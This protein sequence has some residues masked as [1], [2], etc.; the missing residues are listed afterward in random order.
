MKNFIKTLTFCLFGITS[1]AQ[2]ATEFDS[3]SVKLPRYASEVAVTTAIP[4]PTQGMLIYRNDTKS[5]WYF[6][7]TDWKN[8]EISSVSIPTPL[9][10]VSNTNTFSSETQDGASS[11]IIGLNSSNGGGYGIYGQH[12]GNGW[13]GY[14]LGNNAISA[15]GKTYL[16]GNVEIS[17]SNWLEFGKGLTKQ[18][19][20][21]KIVYNAFGEANTL[22]IVGGGVAS[23]GSDRKIKMWANGG[24]EFTGSLIT[25]GEIKPNG[26]S[27]NVGQILRSNGNGTMSWGNSM[28]K[29]TY[30]EILA[31][32]PQ[33]GDMV[34]DLTF[35]IVRVYNGSEW[36]LI[37]ASSSQD[38]MMAISLKALNISD[39]KI[40][41][42]NNIYITG[43]CIGPV[44]FGGIGISP[45][46]GSSDAFIG[47]FNCNGDILWL[48]R[49]GGAADTGA[50]GSELGI[51]VLGN[52]IMVGYFS[53]T[54]NFN[55]PSSFSNNVITTAGGTDN[56]IA[57]YTSTGD[58][59]WIKRSGGIYS[60]QAYS[61]TSDLFGNL[62][63]TGYFTE[64]ANF[65]T[66]SSFGTNEIVSA[67][68]YDIF[69]AKYNQNGEIIF[70]KRAGGTG[71]DLGASIKVDPSGI[72]LCGSFNS[73]ANF[74]TPNS[75]GSFEVISA[76]NSDI[77]LAKFSLSGD[78]IWIKRA[79]GIGNDSGYKIA[80]S[81][82][83]NVF[84]T[85]SFTGTANFNNPSSF[86]SNELTCPNYNS[87][88]G[89]Y[90]STGN[91]VWISKIEGNNTSIISD[92][93]VKINSNGYYELFITGSYSGTITLD[94]KEI[95]SKGVDHDIFISAIVK[96]PTLPNLFVQ[97][98]NTAGSIGYDSGVGIELGIGNKIIVAARNSSNAQ[99]GATTISNSGSNSENDPG[100]SLIF[101]KY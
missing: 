82:D 23:N 76:G 11:S 60:D 41:N 58:L 81:Q 37:S 57:K 36:L 59:L 53:N 17:N 77:F 93:K 67:G 98:L 56:F 70:F 19:D 80:L 25:S 73:V 44:N 31:L 10:L 6:D 79:G 92:I 68:G 8:M 74:N 69:I 4:T 90:S 47:K 63:C 34:Y 83:G 26:N 9:D 40:D 50:V 27:G 51:D 38:L 18:E 75:S 39:I 45:Y 12:K 3:K 85:G 62:Y 65:N 30:T 94:N 28:Q 15:N 86:G 13:A 66:P 88:F 22:S 64:T 54:I 49:A 72:Y 55:N 100:N 71:F 21:G 29:L 7:G 97:L 14:F 95:S 2:Q 78:A 43:Y 99:I 89:Q 32:S 42:L 16:N 101:L 91:L 35:K 96:R 1:Y 52:I 20:N 61:V 46:P 24:T 84:I 5:N 33:E 48:K 87:F